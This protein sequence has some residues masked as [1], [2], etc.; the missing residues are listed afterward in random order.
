MCYSVTD[1]PPSPADI[2]NDLAKLVN[3]SQ[4]SD[5]SFN[6]NR[7]IFHGHRAI[8]S[9]RS[10]YFRAMFSFDGSSQKVKTKSTKNYIYCITIKH[11]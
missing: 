1:L 6:V 7:N 3:N 5:V 11:L 9:V 8:M 2:T 4:F 10:E